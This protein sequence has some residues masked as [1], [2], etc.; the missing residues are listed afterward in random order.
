MGTGEQNKRAEE[1]EGRKGLVSNNGGVGCCKQ[2]THL[3]RAPPTLKP[4]LV[5]GT[6]KPQG[7]IVQFLMFN[8]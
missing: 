4:A 7:D 6:G 2:I 3:P 8:F 5:N 1:R